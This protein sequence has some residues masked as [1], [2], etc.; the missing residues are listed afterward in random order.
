[1]VCPSRARPARGRLP[2]ARAR[3]LV[4]ERR[5]PAGIAMAGLLDRIAGHRVN[6]HHGA[7]R[8]IVDEEGWRVA[9]GDLAA[10][11]CTLLGLWGDAGAVHMAMLD[12]SESVVLVVTLPCA[13]GRFPS[14]G[15]THPPAVRLERA[16]R[17][18]FGLRPVGLADSRPWLDLGF[19]E[20]THPL[21]GGTTAAASAIPY[22]FLPPP[23]H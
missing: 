12:E 4:P 16:I 3:R 1:N 17:S 22:S 10:G 8:V 13:E 19:W 18:L 15:A 23:G 21:A 2:A 20:V 7:P 11:Q 9:S 5:Q 14:V 6:E